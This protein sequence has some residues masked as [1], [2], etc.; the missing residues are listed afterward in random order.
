MSQLGKFHVV[1]GMHDVRQLRV[2]HPATAERMYGTT[3]SP[4]QLF[5]TTLKSA[6]YSDEHEI[7]MHMHAAPMLSLRTR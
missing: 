5:D 3:R 6:Y 4:R 1:A 7:L 2:L